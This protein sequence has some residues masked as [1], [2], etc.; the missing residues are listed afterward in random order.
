MST[1]SFA[2]SNPFIDVEHYLVRCAAGKN[3]LILFADSLYC[4]RC[5]FHHMLNLTSG[6]VIA[7]FPIHRTE[8]EKK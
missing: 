6:M 8:S 2:W 4:S 5:S 7:S 1:F 3:Q